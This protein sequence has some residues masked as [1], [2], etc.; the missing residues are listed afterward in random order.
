MWSAPFKHEW[1]V[2]ETSPA[3][4]ACVFCRKRKCGTG[5]R[6]RRPERPRSQYFKLK[7]FPAQVAIAQGSRAPDAAQR[8]AQR[9]GAPPIRGPDATTRRRAGAQNGM[10]EEWVP[11]LRCNTMRCSAP[12]TRG[13]DG[14][15]CAAPGTRGS[16]CI[17]VRKSHRAILRRVPRT[18]R[19]VKRSGTVRRRSG[20]QTQRRAAA[21]GSKMKCMK[22]GS[23]V[24]AA[25]RCVAARPGHEAE[26]ARAAPRP[27]REAETALTPPPLSTYRR[28]PSASP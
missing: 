21:P 7:L 26:T 16:V 14:A 20:A 19:S 23:R 2:P 9:N 18:R 15:C 27:G 11:G 6:P 5:G 10:H 4:R 22:K 8:E 13:R 1:R 12:G 24:C 28:A 25:T 17:D 3:R